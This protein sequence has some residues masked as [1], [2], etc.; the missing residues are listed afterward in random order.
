M[1][2]LTKEGQS[3][4]GTLHKIKVIDPNSFEIEN[5]TDYTPYEG[6]GTVKNMK[7]IRKIS[8]KPLEEVQK[9]PNIDS[10]LEYY[11]WSKSSKLKLLHT[12]FLA[13]SDFTKQYLRLPLS[14]N[15]EDATNLI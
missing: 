10:N 11:D 1:K 4:N 7:T 2:S 12:L 14:W 9:E 3:I 15:K 6:E 8:F 13:L 5:T